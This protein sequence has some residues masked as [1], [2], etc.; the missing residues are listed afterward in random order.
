MT[1]ITRLI[2]N[3]R[4]ILFSDGR[5]IEY[6]G[7]SPIIISDQEKKI[8][9]LLNGSI[10]ISG[11]ADF[12]KFIP[13]GLPGIDGHREFKVYD[14]LQ[15]YLLI[16]EIDNLNANVLKNMANYLTGKINVYHEGFLTSGPSDIDLFITFHEG[17]FTHIRLK[18][19]KEN[20]KYVWQDNNIE[21]DSDFDDF[22]FCTNLYFKDNQF[23][24]LLNVTALKI[25]CEELNSELIN[26]M[27]EGEIREFGVLLYEKFETEYKNPTVGPF[28][29][30]G[31]VKL[32]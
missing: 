25:Y 12:G 23:L 26:Q 29:M 24:S 20:D 15:N 22:L 5:K 18:I 27:D 14:E 16:N 10:G 11:A 3:E 30:Y 32:E 28:F 21:F 13:S 7:N 17:T 2:T 4:T 6:R 1:L 9:N 8:I 31:D 19:W